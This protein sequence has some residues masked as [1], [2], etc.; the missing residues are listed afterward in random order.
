MEKAFEDN[1]PTVAEV[2][3]AL[4]DIIVKVEKSILRKENYL[5]EM[6]NDV[7]TLASVVQQKADGEP[8]PSDSP[9][10]SYEE[11]QTDLEKQIKSSESS[12]HRIEK[13]K[14]ELAAYKYYMENATE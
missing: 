12:L 5:K 8:L 14:A 9:Y 6:E 13:E 10:T 4:A 7:T 1:I 11:W 2:K 3:A